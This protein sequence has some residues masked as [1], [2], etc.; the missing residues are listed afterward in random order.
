MRA[1]VR[2]QQRYLSQFYDLYDDFHIVKM[3]L[4][5]EEV[6]GVEAIREFSANLMAPY[7]PPNEASEQDRVRELE[8]QV[9][10]LRDEC[11]SLSRQLAEALGK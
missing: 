9:A 3:P 4:L 6:R 1:R 2:M 11:Q 5:E 10:E 8:Q 7:E